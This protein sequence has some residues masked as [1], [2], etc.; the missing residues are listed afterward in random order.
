M[1]TLHYMRWEEILVRRKLLL[2]S[3][4]TNRRRREERGED[5]VGLQGELSDL[6]QQGFGL[7]LFPLGPEEMCRAAGISAQTADQ[8]LRVRG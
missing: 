6:L 8:L 4:R 3:L 2:A 1:T 7:P 5:T